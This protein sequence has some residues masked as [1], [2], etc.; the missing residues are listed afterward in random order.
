MACFLLLILLRMGMNR[1]G[2]RRGQGKVVPGVG[3]D[4]AH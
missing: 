1:G 3:A 2:R 4:N